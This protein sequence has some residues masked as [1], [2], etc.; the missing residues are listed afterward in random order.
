MVSIS[1]IS[2]SSC[3][4]YFSAWFAG[5]GG[6]ALWAM[7]VPSR[8]CERLIARLRLESLRKKKLDDRKGCFRSI[9]HLHVRGRFSQVELTL[10]ATR[11]CLQFASQ[12][13]A[14]SRTHCV[15]LNL[16]CGRLKLHVPNF[17]VVA[18]RT[19]LTV[20]WSQRLKEAYVDQ[21]F[22]VVWI[23]QILWQLHHVPVL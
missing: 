11:R 1:V 6:V 12:V 21:L 13:V 17:Q 23:Y 7:A 19:G 2:R 9:W 16:Q 15:P 10:W 20:M 22:H 5:G 8:A 4:L 14:F 3:T 18:I